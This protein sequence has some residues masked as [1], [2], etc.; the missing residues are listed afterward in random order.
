MSVMGVSLT[1]GW[2]LYFAFASAFGIAFASFPIGIASGSFGTP[3]YILARAVWVLLMI[4]PG[5]PSG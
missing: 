1:Y 5:T 2:P 4:G 3:V